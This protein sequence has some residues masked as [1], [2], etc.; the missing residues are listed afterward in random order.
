MMLIMLLAEILGGFLVNL[1]HCHFQSRGTYM[2]E[3]KQ[4]PNWES[5]ESR[6]MLGEKEMKKKFR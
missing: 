2:G 6:F 1:Y 3:Y 5:L 4:M